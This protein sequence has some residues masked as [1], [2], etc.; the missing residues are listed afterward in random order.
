MKQETLRTAAFFRAWFW[1]RR[2]SWLCFLF[3]CGIFGV[4]FALYH[5]PLGAVLYPAA[6]SLVVAATAAGLDVYR[7]LQTHRALLRLQQQADAL[8]AQQL[9]PPATLVEED[10]QEL[11]QA[12]C[13]ALSRQQTENDAR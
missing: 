8:T 2:R 12:L 3:C 6:L 10:Y 5:L 9:L 11:V 1:Q 4:V 7:T 13:A